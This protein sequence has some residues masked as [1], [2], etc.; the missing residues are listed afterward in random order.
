M[1]NGQD[2]NETVVAGVT[3][4]ERAIPPVDGVGKPFWMMETQVT[5]ELYLAVMDK[6]PSWHIGYNHFFR[7]SHALLQRPVENVSWEDG[8]RFANAL[9]T[10]MGF[11][12]AYDGNDK[13][14][15]LIEGANGFRL[16]FEAEWEW[17]ARC[18]K[19]YR[20]AGSDNFD[21][22]AWCWDNSTNR[23][24]PVGLKEANAW[25]LYDMSGNVYEW[26]FD[27]WNDPHFSEGG[28]SNPIL[29]DPGPQDR[30]TKGG[31]FHDG[32]GCASISY[33]RAADPTVRSEDIGL[34][35]VR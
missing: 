5:Q 17:A 15:L 12:P 26:V 1:N 7:L 31:S 6:N 30:T 16:P 23:P 28:V 10:A 18:G 32:R 24:H 22:V 2:R 3:F 21:D 14:P 35:L 13:N 25:G 29:I 20:Y 19:V 4:H 11:Q 9:S 33:R 27:K 8:I 34:R